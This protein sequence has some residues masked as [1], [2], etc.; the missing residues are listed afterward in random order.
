MDAARHW[1]DRGGGYQPPLGYDVLSPTPEGSLPFFTATTADADWPKLEP[2][3]RATDYQ[4]KGYRLDSHQ[5]PTFA[6]RWQ[7]VDVEERFDGEGKGV[8]PDGKLVRTLTVKGDV[9]PNTWLRLAA[10]DKIQAKDGG[11]MVDA[12]QI[13]MSNKAYENKFR[14]SAEGAVLAGKNLVVPVKAG[15]IKVTYQWLQ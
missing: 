10:S 6:Y 1:N 8:S 12:G 7:G 11:F 3:A 15:Q 14:I 9:A 2:K 4:W 13:K 5:M